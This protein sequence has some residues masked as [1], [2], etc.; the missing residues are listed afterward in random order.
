MNLK[1][2]VSHSLLRRLAGVGGLKLVSVLSKAGLAIF[3]AR[4]LGPEH[5][6]VYSLAVAWLGLMALPVGPG[7]RQYQTRELARLLRQGDSAAIRGFRR[8]FGAWVVLA[9]VAVVA[10]AYLLGANLNEPSEQSELYELLLIGSP[11]LLFLGF[12]ATRESTLRGAGFAVKAHAPELL[13]RPVFAFSCALVL[14][15]LGFLSARAM[16]AAQ[17]LA[18]GAALAVGVWLLRTTPLASDLCGNEAPIYPRVA[19]GAFVVFLVNVAAMLS[20]RMPL[21][22][23]GYTSLPDVAG[24]LQVAQTATGLAAMP[25]AIVTLVVAPQL[26]RLDVRVDASEYRRVFNGVTVASLILTA[27]AAMP[28]VLFSRH[29]VELVFGASYVADAAVPMAI[30]AAGQTL[31]AIFGPVGVTLTMS[32]HERLTLLGHLVALVVVALLAVGLVPTQGALGA[33]IAIA[34]GV[35]ARN[36]LLAYLLYR[37]TAIISPLLTLA[38][39]RR[40]SA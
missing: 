10:V 35:L 36:V 21:L 28:L 33:A 27:T 15:H 22:V 18:A 6:G 30:I 12:N 32:G 19:A 25:V 31:G 23:V 16:I 8:I 3:L 2:I 40:T 1:D 5:F 39:V 7:F 9:S 11:M 20:E 24:A 4:S 26:G 14:L 38:G 37:Q 13:V 29:V 17:V 34:C